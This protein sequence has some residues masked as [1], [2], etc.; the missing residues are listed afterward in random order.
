VNK[1][2]DLSLFDF[3]EEFA[4]EVQEG[5]VDLGET[6]ATSSPIVTFCESFFEQFFAAMDYE[7]SGLFDYTAKEEAAELALR[8]RHENEEGTLHT[9]AV[10][11]LFESFCDMYDDA[12][13]GLYGYGPVS[14]RKFYTD[15]MKRLLRRAHE[16]AE[17]EGID[18]LAERI[19]YVGSIYDRAMKSQRWLS[20]TRI[21]SGSALWRLIWRKRTTS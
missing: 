10:I 12:E 5:N 21:K 3:I 6:V 11:A 4:T 19:A 17:T 1:P 14:Y 9:R 2:I 15:Y 16:W 7:I 8:L 20:R 18:E 13:G